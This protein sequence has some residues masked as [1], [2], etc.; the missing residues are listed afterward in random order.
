M[1]AALIGDIVGS[2]QSPDRSQLQGDLLTLLDDVSARLDHPLAVTLGDEFQGRY[3]TIAEAVAASWFLHLGATPFARLRIGIGW[4]DITVDPGDGSPFGQDGPAWWR[5]RDAIEALAGSSQGPRTL[6][7]TETEWD[8]LTNAYLT[9]RDLHI[10][11]LDEVD[12]AIVLALGDGVTQ[13][14]I[15]EQLGLH[16]SSVSRRIHRRELG[17]LIDA[18]TPSIPLSKP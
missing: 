11:R 2:R 12:A 15:A 3:P 17:S 9:L 10:G 1:Q 7:R 4:G 13:R 16:E 5:G 14:A 18:A 6:V 8:E